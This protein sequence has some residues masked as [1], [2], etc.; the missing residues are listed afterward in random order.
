MRCVSQ[1]IRWISPAMRCIS[2]DKRRGGNLLLSSTV[3]FTCILIFF[4]LFRK[5]K[6]TTMDLWQQVLIETKN[7]SKMHLG[8]SDNV[9]NN[10]VNRFMIISDD[11]QRI[12]KKVQHVHN[13]VSGLDI[14]LCGTVLFCTVL[15]SCCTVLYCTVRN[16]TVLWGTVRY[17]TELHGTERY[18]TVL[19]GTA[20][21]C[22]VLYGTARYWTVLNGTVRYC[23]VSTNVKYLLLIINL[24]C[25]VSGDSNYS[26]RRAAQIS[27]GTSQGE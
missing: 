16:C 24:H 15:N 6:G 22:M 26:A 25:V 5:E 9:S 17:C 19:N 23:T 20:R 18:C 3:H 21:Y 14:L 12:S 11:C 1:A 4:S 27:P 8:L 10:I 13:V 2:W 7:K